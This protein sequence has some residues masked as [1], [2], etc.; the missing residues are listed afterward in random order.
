MTHPDLLTS[1]DAAKL[2]GV[3]PRRLYQW[4]RDGLLKPAA[5][6]PSGRNLFDR[7]DVAR[8]IVAPK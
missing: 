2:A 1:K 4:V 7:A 3:K 5:K 6:T 8:P